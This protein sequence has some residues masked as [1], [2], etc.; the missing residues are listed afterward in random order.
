[1]FSQGH[2]LA[3][4]FGAITSAGWGFQTFGGALLYKRV[5]VGPSLALTTK[6]RGPFRVLLV[7]LLTASLL[8]DRKVWDFKNRNEGITLQN[9]SATNLRPYSPSSSARTHPPADVPNSY[10]PPTRIFR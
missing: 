10:I 9:V 8:F 3:G 7:A 1:M 2:I 5:R 6:A 4:V